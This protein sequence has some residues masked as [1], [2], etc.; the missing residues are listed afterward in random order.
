MGKLHFFFKSKYFFFLKFHKNCR[1]SNLISSCGPF[2]YWPMKIPNRLHMIQTD[3]QRCF[4]R[5]VQQREQQ[6]ASS[7]FINEIKG[8]IQKRRVY[9]CVWGS[10]IVINVYTSYFVTFFPFFLFCIFK[11]MICL[12]IL[13]ILVPSIFGLKIGELCDSSARYS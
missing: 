4:Q 3:I 2:S 13:S 5:I 8:L 10:W 6:A 11:K 9:V 7:I 12:I 1:K